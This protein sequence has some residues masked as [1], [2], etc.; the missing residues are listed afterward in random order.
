MNEKIYCKSEHYNSVLVWIVP[1]IVAMII[2]IRFITWDVRLSHPLWF[3]VL[4]FVLLGPF[5]FW[6]IGSMQIIVTAEKVCGKATF[7]KRVDLPIDSISS[8]G[9]SM[10]GGVDV[11]TSSGR[12][13]FKLVKNKDEIH[14]A[15]SKLLIER[16]QTEKNETAQQNKKSS[17]A[18]ELKKYMELLDSGIITQEE[19]EQKKNQLLDL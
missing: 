18:D 11:G 10:F 14:S 8:V 7:G 4:G 12:I 19:F 2:A 16:Q 6:W 1:I 15:I 9:T 17:N 13:H 5:I 3:I